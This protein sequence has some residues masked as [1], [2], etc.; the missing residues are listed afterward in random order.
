MT[1]W[2]VPPSPQV[3]GWWILSPGSFSILLP[4][5]F[6]SQPDDI[7]LKN[8]SN[9]F[10]YSCIQSSCFAGLC[11]RNVPTASKRPVLLLFWV[12]SQDHL[13]L[14]SSPVALLGY[15]SGP[16]TQAASVQSSCLAGL[17][18]STM[19][20]GSKHSARKPHT[21]TFLEVSGFVG[22]VILQYPYS[23]LTPDFSTFWRLPLINSYPA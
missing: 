11:L 23:L 19:H 13:I 9:L 4:L 16:C 2:S 18:L 5:Y 14:V 1:P 10:P 21:Q 22:V 17:C 8:Y 6:S 12:M 7:I 3:R 20:T 15:V